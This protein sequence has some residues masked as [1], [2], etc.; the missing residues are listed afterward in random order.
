[1][2]PLF[3]LDLVI[4]GTLQ[5]YLLGEWMNDCC[6]LPK[7]SQRFSQAWCVCVMTW[8]AWQLSGWKHL[9]SGS[10][11]LTMAPEHRLGLVGISGHFGKCSVVSLGEEI[12]LWVR[13]KRKCLSV[14]CLWFQALPKQTAAWRFVKT[15]LLWEER[16][17]HQRQLPF[18]S[19]RLVHSCSCWVSLKFLWVLLF[20]EQNLSKQINAITQNIWL[21]VDNSS[22]RTDED[23][24]NSATYELPAGG[25]IVIRG[26][27]GRFRRWGW[28]WIL[29]ST[30]SYQILKK[31]QNKSKY[32]PVLRAI[33]W[34]YLFSEVA[35]MKLKSVYCSMNVK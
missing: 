1:M 21:C 9:S 34:C 27:K 14:E 8:K 6:S 12:C 25:Y 35:E 3:A 28:F 30:K 32:L 5:R 24:C 15:F 20:R 33:F 4:I 19:C 23:S 10:L 26:S 7:Q 13:R 22:G 2:N 11:G 31:K 16:D 29:F 18:K 17:L